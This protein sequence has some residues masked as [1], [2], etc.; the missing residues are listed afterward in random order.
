MRAD[1]S[2][3]TS[4]QQE[5]STGR[6]QR[7]VEIVA[8]V[9]P[10]DFSRLGEEIVSLDR[11][12]IDRF[13]WD[14]MDGHFVPNLTFGPDVIAWARPLTRRPFE[15]HLMVSVP[16][17]LIPLC[18]KAG[19][20]RVIVHAESTAQL[21]RSLSLVRECGAEAGIGLNPATPIEVIA[22]V[23]D[24]VTLVLVM[25]VNP[26]FGGQEYLPSMEPKMRRVRTFL[27]DAG[28]PE[29]GI[30]LDGGIAGDTI[31]GASRAGANVFVAG[32]ALSRDPLGREHAVAELRRLAESAAS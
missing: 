16:D 30:E 5:S 7:P 27:D 15:A 32:S 20:E 8:S 31:G 25:T 3:D 2:S 23:L 26:G 24:L 17:L 28:H 10:C 14:V 12:G 22:H 1:P 21:H 13:Q 11:A 9:L 29:I 6:V 19:C 18:A 4:H